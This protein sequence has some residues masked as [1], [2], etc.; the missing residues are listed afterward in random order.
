MSHYQVDCPLNLSDGNSLTQAYQNQLSKLRDDVDKKTEEIYEKLAGKQNLSRWVVQ[1]AANLI[2]KMRNLL[3]EMEEKILNRLSHERE[4][5]WLQ[6]T[7]VGLRV[8]SFPHPNLGNRLANLHA[9][10]WQYIRLPF[11]VIDVTWE[12][13]ELGNVSEEYCEL[14]LSYNPYALCNNP[15]WDNTDTSTAH[16]QAPNTE[17]MAVD[18]ATG[19]I[20]VAGYQNQGIRVFNQAGCYLSSLNADLLGNTFDVCCTSQFLYVTTASHIVKINKDRGTVLSSNELGFESGGTA[21]DDRGNVYVCHTLE[22][23]VAL[24]GKDLSTSHSIFLQTPHFIFGETIIQ[25]IRLTSNELYVLFENCSYP[26]QCFSLRGDFIRCVISE[27]QIENGSDFCL[28]HHSNILVNEQ[29]GKQIKVFNNNG[30]WLHSITKSGCR[31]RGR[32]KTVSRG[33]A[34]TRCDRIITSLPRAT[35][36]IQVY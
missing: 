25:A 6:Q 30:K 23:E 33:L 28:D 26:I 9:D 27:H 21:V 20:Y 8:S 14:I 36:C 3:E 12:V 1:Q 7:M 22:P 5:N 35:H 16:A 18:E 17:D 34:V 29:F 19:N 31:Q 11:P 2:I 4:M 15:V 13:R 24:F 32:V 10:L